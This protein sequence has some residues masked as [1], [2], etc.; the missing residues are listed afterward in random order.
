MKKALSYVALVVAAVCCVVAAYFC[1]FYYSL[2]RHAVTDLERSVHYFDTR[3]SR[4][5]AHKSREL[6]PVRVFG[7]ISTTDQPFDETLL[8]FPPSPKP[9]GYFAAWNTKVGPL[10]TRELRLLAGSTNTA[11]FDIQIESGLGIVADAW[12]SHGE[13]YQVLAAFE[14]LHVYCPNGTNIVRLL[15]RA[16][17]G[18]S[19]K[20]SFTIVVLCER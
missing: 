10:V 18:A 11:T 2:Y 13:P 17:P 14:Q 7:K 3:L 16:K 4:L 5:E 20:M 9:D 15:A 19:V 1:H 8:S 12:L 6:T